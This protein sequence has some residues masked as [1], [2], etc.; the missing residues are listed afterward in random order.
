[1]YLCLYNSQVCHNDVYVIVSGLLHKSH[2]IHT[3]VYFGKQRLMKR[4]FKASG[5]VVSGIGMTLRVVKV[6]HLVY[7]EIQG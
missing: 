5:M 1:M 3:S 4:H 7:S 6:Q 2:I